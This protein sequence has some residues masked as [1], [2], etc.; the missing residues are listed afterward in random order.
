VGEEEVLE[1][2]N[3]AVKGLEEASN[4]VVQ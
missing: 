1:A 4:T 2:E 3:R